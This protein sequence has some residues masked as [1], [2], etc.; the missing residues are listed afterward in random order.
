M[1]ARLPSTLVTTPLF[2]PLLTQQLRVTLIAIPHLCTF[3]ILG[4]HGRLLPPDYKHKPLRLPCVQAHY[5][6]LAKHGTCHKGVN[7]AVASRGWSLV[8]D[9]APPHPPPPGWPAGRPDG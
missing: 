7:P 2:G 9:E 5:L 1:K 8:D 4:H 3:P 6:T